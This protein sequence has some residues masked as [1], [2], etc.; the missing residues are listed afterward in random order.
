MLATLDA[1]PK[2]LH[3]LDEKTWALP[4]PA[5]LECSRGKSLLRQNT[6]A[7]LGP[8]PAGGLEAAS[9]VTM[10]SE[11]AEDYLVVRDLLAG[12]MDCMRMTS[13]TIMQTDGRG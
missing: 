3:R 9:L 1:V 5:A 11:A 13:P 2:V 6:Q 4:E 8:N 7:L 12:G 10:P